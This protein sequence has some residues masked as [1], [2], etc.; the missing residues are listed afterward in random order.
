MGY[1]RAGDNAALFVWVAELPVLLSWGQLQV[2][3]DDTPAQLLG[4][5]MALEQRQQNCM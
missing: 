1:H 4:R 3:G 2:S 5:P